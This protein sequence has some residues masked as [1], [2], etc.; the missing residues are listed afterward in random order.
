MEWALPAAEAA[1]AEAEVRAA[2]AGVKWAG[3]LPQDQA[4]IACAPTAAQ[5]HH[6]S[7]DSRARSRCV[8]SVERE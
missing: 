2:Q 3:L 5:K 7:Q 8:Q 6:T 1:L 4:V